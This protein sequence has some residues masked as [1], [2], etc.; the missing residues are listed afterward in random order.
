MSMLNTRIKERRLAVGMTLLQ[1][2][3]ALHVK[4][5]T[6]QRYESGDIKN[7]KHET[8]TQLADIFNCNPAYLMG[9]TDDPAI[10]SEQAAPKSED[11]HSALDSQLIDLLRFLSDDQKKMLLA[12]IET[13]LQN[14]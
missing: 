3:D 1:V 2:A 11:G 14:Q 4:E 13:L 9:W 10:I 12:Q 8:V 7:I 6:A 5:A